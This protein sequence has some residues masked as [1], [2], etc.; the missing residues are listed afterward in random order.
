[1]LSTHPP[2]GVSLPWVAPQPPW[3]RTSGRSESC[4]LGEMDIGSVL[5]MC[6]TMAATETR[7]NRRSQVVNIT[8]REDVSESVARP[9]VCRGRPLGSAATL[10]RRTWSCS[11]RSV[12]ELWS[13]AAPVGFGWPPWWPRSHAS[14]SLTCTRNA[15][16]RRAGSLRFAS[17]S[18]RSGKSPRG[19]VPPDGENR[20]ARP[21]L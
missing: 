21:V 20:R 18:N 2:I 16:E 7:T 14:A 11:E 4:R 5:E 1:M 12:R 19:S 3:R 15:S 13:E 10:S 17:G 6:G 9:R 8:A